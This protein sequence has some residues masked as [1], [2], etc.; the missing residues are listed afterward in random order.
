MADLDYDFGIAK[1]ALSQILAQRHADGIEFEALGAGIEQSKVEVFNLAGAEVFDSGFAS[2]STQEWHLINN[3]GQIL[4]N[5][6]YLYVVTV[7]GDDGK[8]L[9]SG[10][11]KLVVLR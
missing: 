3:R 10:V 8:P 5:G 1:L 9:S 6:V 7:K 11:R 4:A 2:G